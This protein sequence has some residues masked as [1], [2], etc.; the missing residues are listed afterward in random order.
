MKR[1]IQS[2]KDLEIIIAN[3]YKKLISDQMLFPFF[4]EIVNTNSLEH[5]LSIIVDFWQD[6]LFQTYL[7]KNNPMQKHLN[8]HQKMKFEKH[9][10]A[11][12]L[13]YLTETID[14]GFQGENALNM[15]TRASSIATVMQ[16]KMNLYQS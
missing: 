14:G 5:H 3:F 13:Q 1:D 11:L 8:F 16:L 12:W 9:H 7:Y 6:L 10:F 2:R 15:K 4:E